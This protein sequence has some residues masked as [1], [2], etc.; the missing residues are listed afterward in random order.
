MDQMTSRHIGKTGAA[1]SVAGLERRFGDLAAVD[2]LDLEVDA[3]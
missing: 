1:I 2:G 3:G